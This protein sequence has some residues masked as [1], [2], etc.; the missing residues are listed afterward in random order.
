MLLAFSTRVA[1]LGALIAL[2]ASFMLVAPSAQANWYGKTGNVGTCNAYGNITDNKNVGF[3]YVDPS[4]Q[5]TEA[6]NY[7]RNQL[8][9]PTGLDTSYVSDST[10][11]TDIM[12]GD[13][14]YTDFCEA[15]LGV[16]WTQNGV[17][18]LRGLTTCDYLVDNGRCDQ[19]VVRYS[20]HFFDVHQDYGDRY[21]VCHEIGHAIGLFHRSS[22]HGCIW[23]NG[24]VSNPE[25]T[26]HDIEHFNSDWTKEPAG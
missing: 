23:N 22:A 19:A 11:A 8:L 5:L 21:L 1:A 16:Q 9:N 24:D 20:N 4:A 18:G 15:A 12:A 17:N 25:Y 13:R 26:P 7:T 14:Y 6:A 3:H 2:V 10:N